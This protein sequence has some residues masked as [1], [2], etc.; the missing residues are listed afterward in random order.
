MPRLRSWCNMPA[1]N[2]FR[3]P[4]SRLM[5]VWIP[6]A[7]LIVAA[8]AGAP[9]RGGGDVKPGL[10]HAAKKDIAMQLVSAAEN[11]SLDWRA[12]YGYIEYN[13]EHD[14]E[15]KRGYTGGLIGFTSRTHDKFE[16][17]A[18]YKS[19]AP[20]DNSLVR[21]LPK[22]RQVDGTPSRDGLG[23]PFERAWLSAANDPRFRA[24]QDYER[25]RIYFDPAVER[26]Q[27]DG[28]RELGQFC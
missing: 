27:A 23:K 22:L 2:P 1:A 28:L 8:C 5:R 3:P 24:A 13:V 21:F 6:L 20:D 7:V 10:T 11:S 9:G 14:A 25:D 12:Q 19:I 4:R 26:A 18:Y 16:L 15:E 17:V